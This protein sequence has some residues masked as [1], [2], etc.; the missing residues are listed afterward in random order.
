MSLNRNKT[1]R[2]LSEELEEMN[3]DPSKFSGEIQRTTALI[4]KRMGGGNGGGPP[5]SVTGSDR[6]LQE[7][8]NKPSGAA[9]PAPASAPAGGEGIDEAYRA[10]RKKRVSAGERL[11]AR[12]QRRAGRS[13]ARRAAKQYRRGA[14]RKIA[15]RR[16]AK[17][18]KFGKAGLEKLHKTGKRIVMGDDKLANLREDLNT[19]VV[20]DDSNPFE[21]AAF[22]AGML[23][24]YLGQIFEAAGDLESAE[25]MFDVSDAAADLSEAWASLAEDDELDEDQQ[26]QLERVL[27][28]TVKALRFYEG[29]GAPSLYD[30]IEATEEEPEADSQAA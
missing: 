22:N 26:A 8:S 28:S 1:V 14:K 10:V 11:K 13:Q 24:L 18:R 23:A 12:R 15:K 5:A 3:L 16:M 7:V 27:E 25:T 20:G 9:P 4:D 21:E 19:G 30:V 6:Q 2:P 17:L 29:M